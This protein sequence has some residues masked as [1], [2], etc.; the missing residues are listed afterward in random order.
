MKLTATS[1][2]EASS[3]LGE[4]GIGAVTYADDVNGFVLVKTRAGAILAQGTKL[5]IR[6]D[7]QK[8]AEV[9]VSPEARPPFV[10]ADI[11]SGAPANGDIAFL[12]GPPNPAD[13]LVPVPDRDSSSASSPAAPGAPAPQANPSSLPE[14]PPLDG[15]GPME[16]PAEEPARIQQPE[17][18]LRERAPT[19]PPPPPPD[20]VPRRVR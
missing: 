9:V 10:A 8:V 2:K 3:R 4:K 19:A 20:F 14:L 12:L 13:K 11:L 5:E 15:P 17:E 7:G 18:I 6:R 16:I 1:V